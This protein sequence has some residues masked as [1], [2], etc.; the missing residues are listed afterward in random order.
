MLINQNHPKICFF[1]KEELT[2]LPAMK[3]YVVPSN[4]V[5]LISR[6]IHVPEKQKTLLRSTKS[7]FLVACMTSLVPATANCMANIQ[8][9][10]M[11]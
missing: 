11:M 9:N 1:G 10:L 8:H 7:T 4:N 2:K 6:V 3:N 5:I